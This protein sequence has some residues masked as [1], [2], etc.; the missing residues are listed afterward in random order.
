MNNTI[1]L[2]FYTFA[3]VGILDTLYLSYHVIKHTDVACWFFPKEWC[4]KV[5]YSKFSK[6][7]GIPNP[8]VGFSMYGAII[9]LTFLSS[10]GFAL[11]SWVYGLVAMGFAFSMYFSFV[12]A[13]ILR[14][15]CIWCVVSAINFTVMFLVMISV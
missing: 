12:Q 14:A 6:T 1:T 15:F 7:L 13:F 2:V 4:R 5:Q 9:V 8:F 10:R 11:E 3:F